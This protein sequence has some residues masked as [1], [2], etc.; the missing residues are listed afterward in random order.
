[1]IIWKE[2]RKNR[3]KKIISTHTFY[4]AN[5]ILNIHHSLVWG[6]AVCELFPAIQLWGHQLQWIQQHLIA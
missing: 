4:A 3:E 2:K 1:M 5:K 6:L